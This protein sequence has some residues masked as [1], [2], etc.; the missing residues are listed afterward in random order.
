MKEIAAEM[1][2]RVASIKKELAPVYF[3]F[4]MNKLASALPSNYLLNVYKI[5][6]SV[7]SESSQQFLYDIQNELKSI[8]YGLPLI[9]LDQSG[10]IM[11]NINDK[12][13]ESYR[14]FVDKSIQKVMGRF[15]VMGYPPDPSIIRDGYQQILDQI[16]KNDKNKSKEDL[17]AILTLRGLATKSNEIK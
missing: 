15:K 12:S 17:V 13:S 6:K 8:L 7:S 3:S 5:K 10:K 2:N 11:M 9:Q 14:T 1:Q 4:L 16:D